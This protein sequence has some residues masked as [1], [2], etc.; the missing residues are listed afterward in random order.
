[1]PKA[2]ACW[3][4]MST[5]AVTVAILLATPRTV[6]H[7]AETSERACNSGDIWRPPARNQCTQR[8]QE[9]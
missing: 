8:S 6:K 9:G 3:S 2:L 1:M 4:Q 7:V 5:L